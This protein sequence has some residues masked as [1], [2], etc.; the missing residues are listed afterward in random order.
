MPSRECLEIISKSHFLG[1]RSIHSRDEKW[2]KFE[3]DIPSRG[4]LTI[5]NGLFTGKN[6]VGRC[7]VSKNS[8]KSPLNEKTFIFINKYIHTM[9]YEVLRT[10]RSHLKVDNR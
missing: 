5:Q 6:G 10:P 3:M 7:I 9:N 2:P 1:P 4:L 8:Y